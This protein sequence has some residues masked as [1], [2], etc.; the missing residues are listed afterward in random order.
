VIVAE[1]GFL[2]MLIG[3]VWLAAEVSQFRFAAVRKVGSGVAFALGGLLLIIATHW[4][5]FGEPGADRGNQL[6]AVARL[7]SA[8][9]W[10][11]IVFRSFSGAVASSRPVIPVAER[12]SSPAR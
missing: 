7:A 8:I 1:V 9:S 10:A 5:H 2:L 11:L 4:G 3:G 6:V 12:A